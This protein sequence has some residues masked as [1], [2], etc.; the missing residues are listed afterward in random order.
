MKENLPFIGMIKTMTFSVKQFRLYSQNHPITQQ[1]LTALNLE[2][3]KFF[4]TSPRINLGS[5]RKLLVV[6]GAIVSEKESSAHE[7]AKEFDRLGIEALTL[8]KGVDVPEMSVFLALMAT[9]TKLLEQ[10]G[11]FRKAYEQN[12]LPHIKLVSGRYELVGDGEAVLS[13]KD[14][15][16]QDEKK[17]EGSSSPVSA[18]ETPSEPVLPSMIN[19]MAD[20]IKKLR[21]ET[22]SAGEAAV[23]A[24]SRNPLTIDYE[25]VVSQLE[26]NPQE[27]VQLTIEN[28]PNS[29][30]LEAVIRKLVKYLTQGLA[31]YLAEQ[32][33]DITKA[34][35][36]LAK[37]FE[38]AISQ[39]LAGEEFKGIQDKIP[40]IFAEAEDEMRVQMM[41]EVHK[42]FPADPKIMQKLAEKLFKDEDV[43]KR[44]G[45][46]LK[47]ELVRSGFT[48]EQFA[49]LFDKVEEKIAKKK[50]RIT[51]DAEEFEELRG[52]AEKF[53][54]VEQKYKKKID[55]IEKEKKKISDE[56]ERV[57]S[58]VRNLAEGV[59]VVDKAGKVLLMNPAAEKLLGVKQS[60]KVGQSVSEGLKE[61]QLVSLTTGKIKDSDEVDKK[62]E[63]ISLNDETRRVLQASTAVIENEDG[64]TVGMVSVLSDV[65]KQRQLADLKDQF[66]SNVSHELR[67]PL[68]AIE[69]S[70]ALIMDKELGDVNPEQQ[71]FLEIAHRNIGR[72]SRLIN[73]LLDVSKLEAGKMNLKPE[74]V[75][76]REVAGHVLG[77][78]QT[79]AKG[80]NVNLESKWTDE[81]M[82]VECDPDRLTQVL[83]N[84]VGNA[85][86]FTPENGTVTIEAFHGI[87][88]PK[89]PGGECVEI[90]VRDTGIG[91]APED[92][93]RIFQKFEQVSLSQPQ[94]V[95]STGLGLT[96][97]KEIVELHGGRIWV[98]SEAGRG[99][100][101]VFRLPVKFK[102]PKQQPIL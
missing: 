71:K 91:I 77:T 52:K 33:K 9:P 38:K 64:Q 26:K 1:A 42:K 5:M 101:F 29:P 50:S 55:K 65:T 19:S 74:F 68:V 75:S 97:V 8:E 10:K 51:V 27:I 12:P 37:E 70:L 16:S 102:A 69:K 93:I 2:M 85:L 22:S 41:L 88:D 84:L 90:G 23:P 43:R 6:N 53:E 44:L 59:L 24:G 30:E 62:V 61:D 76:V 20:I 17:E 98:E 89:I 63:V 25:K 73:D 81:K 94:G 31:A 45:P 72:L 13:Q 11:G 49:V 66:V 3:M 40:G 83:T 86:K 36:K 58:V 80:K 15:P 56:K 67:T 28:V 48:S 92:Q 7:L 47:E 46:G 60:D 82:T 100:R 57:D 87:Q 96:I 34:M 32:G 95:S 14:S 54:E 39:V 21:L 99:S 35:Q 18:K 78:I 79:W 4:E